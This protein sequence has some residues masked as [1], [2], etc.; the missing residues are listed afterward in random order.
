MINS[1]FKLIRPLNV[2]IA[3]LTV[4]VIVWALKK[5]NP[6]SFLLE[7]LPVIFVCAAGNVLNDFFDVEIDKINKP[8]RPLV[9]KEISQK[10]AL[11]FAVLLFFV[12]ILIASRLKT[13]LFVITIFTTV[14]IVCYDWKLKKTTLFGNFAVS[15]ASGMVFLYAGLIVLSLREAFVPA[16]MGFLFHFARE[17]LKDIEDVKGDRKENAQTFPIKF[18]VKNAKIL[19]TTTVFVL[20]LVT[21]LAYKTEGYS[22]AYL[23]A[24]IFTVDLQLF[25]VV[26]S[27][28]KNHSPQNL[29]RLNKLLKIGMLLGL[30]ALSVS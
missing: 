9:L 15:L 16:L 19:V 18:G 13:E 4:F 2:T 8:N 23:L 20:V 7:T 3:W 28:W 14:L 25:F 27:L 5:I 22:L 6:F 29:N 11:Y 12:A 17:I 10:T 26:I 21:V 24:V 30:L 1:Y